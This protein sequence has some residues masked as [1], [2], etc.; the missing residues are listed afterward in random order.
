MW[1]L[2]QTS[3]L[4][5][6]KGTRNAVQLPVIAQIDLSK[7]ERRQ[8]GQW[9]KGSILCEQHVSI[10]PGACLTCRDAPTHG[11][12]L[13]I[14]LERVRGPCITTLTPVA[15][16]SCTAQNQNTRM[17]KKP[18]V[19]TDLVLLHNDQ[20]SGS[21]LGLVKLDTTE[22]GVRSEPHTLPGHLTA[23]ICRQNLLA[24]VLKGLDY[25]SVSAHAVC[26]GLTADALL[27][28]ATA[29]TILSTARSSGQAQTPP[30]LP[31][32]SKIS[33]YGHRGR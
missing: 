16:V 10:G 14:P 9:T 6:A 2:A 19:E 1:H 31:S 25:G 21:S 18:S 7:V 12:G 23:H 26:S 30:F 27:R 8:H 24:P 15:G 17:N 3:A 33:R 32:R 13:S 11:T 4:R 22:H 29:E 20:S 5:Y 28:T